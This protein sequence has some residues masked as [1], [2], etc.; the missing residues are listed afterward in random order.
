MPQV[1]TQKKTVAPTESSS[2]APEDPLVDPLA[3]V[4][5]DQLEKASV[6]GKSSSKSGFGSKLLGGFK[7]I[8]SGISGFMEKRSEK[9][10]SNVRKDTNDIPNQDIVFEQLAHAGAYG[11]LDNSKLPLWGYSEA[12]VIEDSSSGFRAVLYLPTAA[13]LGSGED[14][15]LPRAIHGGTPPPVLE[16]RGTKNFRGLQEDVNIQGVGSYQFRANRRVIGD[17]LSA[18]G[19]K[20][21][22]T[23]HSL[24]GALAQLTAA[25]LPGGVGRVVTFQ[26][27]GIDSGDAAL[28]AKH[29]EEADPEDQISS[30]H[31]R[32]DGDVVHAAGEALT[33]GDVHTFHS[34]GISNPLD[35]KQFMLARLNQARDGLIPGIDPGGEPVEDT[36]LRVKKTSSS[37]E[38]GGLKNGIA[39]GGRKF[40]GGAIRDDSSDTYS[41]LW[42]NVELMA[43]SGTYSSKRVFS[44]IDVAEGLSLNEKSRMKISAELL[45]S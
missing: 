32:A 11:S 31:Y 4:P 12:K 33:K 6:G 35:H 28:L 36:L 42:N 14:S 20:A 26:S 10:R 22:V 24:G 41:E 25:H 3:S 44:V 38:K 7:A 8:G 37:D 34:K 19:G 5:Q 27:P 43:K 45:M 9:R 13:A 23:G 2:G 30:S 40:L 29:N 21:V 18:A 15:V 39:E 17:L 16:L 1:M